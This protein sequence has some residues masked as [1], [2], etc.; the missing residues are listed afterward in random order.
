MA[1]ENRRHERVRTLVDIKVLPLLDTEMAP[2]PLQATAMDLSVS[3]M[4]F[5]LK[6]YL[7][8][9]STLTVLLELPG[10]TLSVNAMVMRREQAKRSGWWK[11]AVK[12]RELSDQDR[13][14]LLAFIKAES[15]RR[16]V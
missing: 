14:R 2:A 11:I 10:E 6:R 5:I 1:Y 9:N 3:G 15:K 12:F 16:L 8:I 4:A 13:F 7:E